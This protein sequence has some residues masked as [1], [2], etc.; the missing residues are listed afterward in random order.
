MT[1][2]AGRGNALRLAKTGEVSVAAESR[3]IRVTHLRKTY[4][5]PVAV[6]DVS[7]WPKAGSSAS[8]ARTE[9][10]RP[11]R[12]RAPSALRSPDAGDDPADGHRSAGVQ[13]IPAYK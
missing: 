2:Q 12:L 6:D 4:G 10:G 8:S 5:S 9:P 13:P 11:P 7:F 1:H 3:A